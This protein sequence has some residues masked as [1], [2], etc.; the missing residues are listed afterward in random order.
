MSEAKAYIQ[1]LFAQ[2]GIEVVPERSSLFD[3]FVQDPANRDAVLQIQQNQQTL[4]AKW[5]KDV[6]INDIKDQAFSIP[7]ATVGKPYETVIDIVRLGWQDLV[8]VRLEGLE[9]TGLTYAPESKTLSGV[10]QK[11]GDI[12]L[13][14]RFG[15]QQVDGEEFTKPVMLIIN[16]DPR[17]LWKN[18][19]SDT[20]DPYWK[21]DD[22]A[23]TGHL[24][25]RTIVVA[26]RRGRSHANVGS[27]RDDD[28]SFTHLTESG[29]SVVAVSDGAGSAV[30]S[31]EAS[32]LACQTVTEYFAEKIGT[33][34]FAGLD[35]AL[36]TYSEAPGADAGQQLQAQIC[37]MLAQAVQTVYQK[38]EAFAAKAGCQMKDLHATLVFALVKK[39]APGY[40]ILTFGVGDCPIAVLD[41]DGA[42]V[43]LM[44]KLDVGEFG[45]GTRFV[46]MPEI[47]SNDQ[48]YTRFGFTMISD[49]AYLM[50]M[51]DGIYDPKFEVEA[52]LAKPEKWNALLADLDG[53]NAE[54]AKV[55]LNRDNPL[56]AQQLSDWMNF[57]SPGNHDDRTLAIIF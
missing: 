17:S 36:A 53:N 16:P 50:L 42:T 38:L 44:N 22:V 31:R 49:F 7:N 37:E 33:A 35:A 28:F 8:N 41:K 5:L 4:M 51:T 24:G 11:S 34:T 40:A 45:G 48:F 21:Q 10:P 19:A 18:I 47:Y 25:D 20:A 43:K 46:T 30:L 1:S 29:W 27:F 9:E 14:L 12:R 3:A 54:G 26:S 23:V 6:R 55:V 57:W 56:L 2:K 13:T 39:Y 52:S 32:R 15:L